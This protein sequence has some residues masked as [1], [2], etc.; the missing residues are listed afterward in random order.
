M[1]RYVGLVVEHRFDVIAELQRHRF[2]QPAGD[3]D[4]SRVELPTPPRQL[5]N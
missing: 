2:G 3:D 4:V 1:Y 5:R